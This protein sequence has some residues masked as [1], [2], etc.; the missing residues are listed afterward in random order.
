MVAKKQPVGAD[1][2][3]QRHAQHAAV[4]RGC[5]AVVVCLRRRR[6]LRHLY[7]VQRASARIRVFHDIRLSSDVVGLI[8]QMLIHLHQRWCALRQ[9]GTCPFQ[10]GAGDIPPL[11]QLRAV[12]SCRRLAQGWRRWSMA[13]QGKA[14]LTCDCGTAPVFQ[15]GCVTSDKQ[16][17]SCMSVRIAVGVT[18]APTHPSDVRAAQ[19]AAAACLVA[20]G[21][22]LAAGGLRKAISSSVRWRCAWLMD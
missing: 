7:C 3:P 5:L 20:E 19:R 18:L 8:L 21:A 2:M 17:R 9:V 11:S 15:M 13:L 10:L 6:V 16:Q 14:Q 4:A 22:E 1:L 12:A